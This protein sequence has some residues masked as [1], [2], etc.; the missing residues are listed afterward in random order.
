MTPCTQWHFYAGFAMSVH[1][2]TMG[3]KDIIPVSLYAQVKPAVPSAGPAR[4]P[5]ARAC[6]ADEPAPKK[7]EMYST[8]FYQACA[9]GGW[10]SCGLTHMAVT[11]LDVVKC[12]MQIDPTKY[13][14]IS[15]GFGIVWKEAG[16]GGLFR[17]WSPTLIGYGF[18]GMCKFGFYEYFKKYGID[19]YPRP[20]VTCLVGLLTSLA[21]E[22]IKVPVASLDLLTGALFLQA[23]RRPRRPGD[24]RQIPDP[25]FPCRLSFRRGHRRRGAVPMGGRQGAARQARGLTRTCSSPTWRHMHQCCGAALT[26][27]IA[28]TSGS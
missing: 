11:P 14:S 28:C 10:M 24:C 12:N 23:L 19:L 25:P 6:S 1:S 18:Q 26:C 20:L 7:I 16:I 15:S 5:R 3:L 4:S 27:R 17:G 9:I 22:L 2:F 21:A 13:K 8:E